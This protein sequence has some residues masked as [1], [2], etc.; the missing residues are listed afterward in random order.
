MKADPAD[1]I[2][3]LAVQDADTRLMQLDHRAATLPESVALA[4]AQGRHARL[5]DEVVAA[6]TIL[7]DLERDQARADADV[8]QVRDRSARDRQLL[9]S[10]TIGDPKQLQSLQHELESL[11]RRQS[12]LEDVELEVMERVEG[13]RA[14]VQV[15]TRDRDAVAAEISDLQAAVAAA[16]GGIEAERADVLADRASTVT[17]VAADLLTLYE[18][19]RAAHGGVGAARLYRGRCE[20]C[21]LDIP[22]QEIEAIRAAA[23][24][25]VLHCEE[26]RR[27]LVRTSES[28]L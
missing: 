8:Q 20:G 7:S 6:E 17:G 28:G 15:L 14:A 25:T 23:A 21:H 12:D 3:L 10:G 22:P 13:A 9:D 11:A 26:C 24:D 19:T 16:M 1:Q 5:R 4:D 18:K 2:R 27:I